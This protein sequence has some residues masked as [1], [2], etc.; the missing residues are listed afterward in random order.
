MFFTQ[1]IF[2]KSLDILTKVLPFSSVKVSINSKNSAHPQNALQSLLLLPLL[3]SQGAS[4]HHCL[5]GLQSY[6]WRYW[7]N[8]LLAAIYPRS[9]R[10]TSSSLARAIQNPLR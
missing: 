9:W 10:G 1:N 8:V 7:R 6:D 3:D 2:S 4:A 5:D